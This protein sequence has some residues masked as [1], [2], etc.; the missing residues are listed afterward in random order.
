[1]NSKKNKIEEGSGV[2][3]GDRVFER[4]GMLQAFMNLLSLCWKPF[5][6]HDGERLDQIGVIGATNFVGRDGLLWY[7]DIGKY[8]TG[9]FSLAV[10]Q[11]NLV[12]EDHFQIESGQFGTFVGVYDGHGGP[13]AARYVCDNMFNHFQG[14]V[15]MQQH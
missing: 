10:V 5:G 9:D 1:M 7:R 4:C 11:A 12:L 14:F 13:E 15:F 6:Q 2:R 3:V 8:A